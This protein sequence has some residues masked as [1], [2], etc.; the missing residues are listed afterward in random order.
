MIVWPGLGTQ[1]WA[2]KDG[3]E[4]L[5]SPVLFFFVNCNISFGEGDFKEYESG[6]RST[7]QKHCT[8]SGV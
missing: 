4:A 7:S 2:P 5:L 6:G 3:L 8:E 1:G